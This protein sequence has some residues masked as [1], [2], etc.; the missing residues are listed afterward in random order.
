MPFLD[1]LGNRTRSSEWIAM[2][3]YAKRELREGRGLV[4]D[5][6]HHPIDSQATQSDDADA[7]AGRTDRRAE[8][9]ISRFPKSG[10]GERAEREIIRL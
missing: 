8:T 9:T 7:P 3:R 2:A 10:G 6:R 5:F 4:A 1:R